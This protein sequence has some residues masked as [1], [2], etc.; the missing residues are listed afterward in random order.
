MKFGD[1]LKNNG[2]HADVT[3]QNYIYAIN[4]LKV[5]FGFDDTTNNLVYIDS[6]FE[7]LK[8]NENFIEINKKQHHVFT[9]AMNQYTKYKKYC[10]TVNRIESFK[11][12]IP[13][14]DV[15]NI[16][17]RF[18][19]EYGKEALKQKHGK[20]LLLFIFGPK[21]TNSII[22]NV[23]F[24]N[25]Y[26]DFAGGIKGGTSY[27][28]TLFYSKTTNQWIYGKQ[29]SSK[30]ISEDEAIEYAEQ[31]KTQFIKCFDYIETH[32]FESKKDYKNLSIF[33]KKSLNELLYLRGWISKYFYLLYPNVFFPLHAQAKYMTWSKNA[34]DDLSLETGNDLII[35]HGDICLLS[36]DLKISTHHLYKI[37]LEM[38][39]KNDTTTYWFYF[40][41]PKIY[42]H[43]QAFKDNG[44]IDWNCRQRKHNIG[45]VIFIYS[46][47]D[48]KRV[49]YKT[50]VVRINLS[51]KN[52][53][54]DQKYWIDSNH[55]YNKD[56]N[57]VRLKLIKETNS[58]KGVLENLRAH[59]YPYNMQTG[60]RL[61]NYPDLLEYISSIFDENDTPEQPNP[62]K[63]QE[64]DFES[65]IKSSCNKI[66]YGTPG[67]GKSYYVKHTI[68]KNAPKEN[69]VRTT[70]HQDYTNT[71]FVGQILPR[72]YIPCMFCIRC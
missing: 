33:L 29:N 3:I 30:A 52:I 53:I 23:E 34:F 57:F 28:F 32:T 44:F 43:N 39:N 17:S 4:N 64:Y 41:N 36:K 22:Y 24:N 56:D 65:I 16:L 12:Q 48:E 50:E 62:V 59:G 8:K 37:L 27:K 2:Y 66:I 68:T 7:K 21:E 70:F 55:N 46:S 9:A 6:E 26:I 20:D 14:G 1:W 31:V 69:V 11:N 40:A 18:K 38:Y 54:D 63:S 60:F 19:S 51:K 42:N 49:R 47:G 67:C 61:D 13:T 35:Q 58:I 10:E 5:K 25:N 72:V 45:D 15:T 71:D